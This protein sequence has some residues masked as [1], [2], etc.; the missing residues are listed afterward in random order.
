MKRVIYVMFDQVA[1]QYGGVFDFANDG[2]MIRAMEN[3]ARSGQIPDYVLRDT[4]VIQL[5]EY[6]VSGN[7]P[8]V[9]PLLPVI[10]CRLEELVHE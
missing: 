2:E 6:D 8:C 3:M 7:A 1:G 10:V 4:V 9:T 5:A